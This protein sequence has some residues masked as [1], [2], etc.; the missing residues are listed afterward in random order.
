[1]LHS[2]HSVNQLVSQKLN[3]AG[4]GRAAVCNDIINLRYGKGV[5]EKELPEFRTIAQQNAQLGI[6]I[7]Y[8]FHS[9]VII[10]KLH[11]A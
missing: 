10:A 4:I 6:T 2:I 1:M 9:D 3:V 5:E 7:K 11:R 8:T